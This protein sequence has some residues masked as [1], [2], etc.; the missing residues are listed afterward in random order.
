M[1]SSTR[2]DWL[3][4]AALIALSEDADQVDPALVLKG[5]DLLTHLQTPSSL[6]LGQRFRFVPCP[7][8][9]AAQHSDGI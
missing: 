8:F 6:I 2:A 7:V 5:N 4:P 9:A 3:V 1:T